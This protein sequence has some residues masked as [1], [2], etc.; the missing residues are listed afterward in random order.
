[1]NHVQQT[2]WDH[3]I[4]GGHVDERKRA[5][6][7]LVEAGFFNPVDSPAVSTERLKKILAN[8]VNYC[9]P[10]IVRFKN[11]V[12]INSKPVDRVRIVIDLD[13]EHGSGP[14]FRLTN[15]GYRNITRTNLGSALEQML[16]KVGDVV[17]NTAPD[18]AT[19]TVV[20]AKVVDSVV[21][22]SNV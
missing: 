19:R 18:A 21:I 6:R 12:G 1:M 15:Q 17:R 5:L 10:G 3:L 8:G 22:V 4:S 11:A 7:E 13:L 14:N 9:G 20:K 16:P 2:A